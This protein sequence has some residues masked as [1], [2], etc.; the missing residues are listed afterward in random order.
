MT[1]IPFVNCN[2]RMLFAAV[3]A[4]ALQ[5]PVTTAADARQGGGIKHV[6]LCW[7][8]EP[9]NA[10]QVR[11]VIETSLELAALP[12]LDAIVGGTALSSDRP[13]VDDSFDVGLVM[14]F[15]DATALEAY[16]RHPEH[17]RRVETVLRPLCGRVQVF[18]ITH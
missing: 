17:V 16:L 1:A 13:I 8:H 3:M 12:E 18:D 15:R 14:D 5:S 6:V 7:L 11:T 2:W 4:G 10:A 9:G